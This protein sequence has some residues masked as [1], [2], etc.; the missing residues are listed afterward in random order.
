MEACDSSVESEISLL[1]SFDS[2]VIRCCVCK[3]N[4]TI[5]VTKMTGA[6]RGTESRKQIIDA[7]EIF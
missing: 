4:T 7:L 6:N 2:K 3:K 5:S 1:S